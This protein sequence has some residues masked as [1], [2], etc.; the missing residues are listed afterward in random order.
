MFRHHILIT[1]RS[2]LC[3]KSTFLINLIGLSTGLAC[4]I[5]IYLWVNSEIEVDKFHLN[6]DRLYQVMFNLNVSG[7]IMTLENT[8]V[9]LAEAM[10]A[11]IPGVEA[12]VATNDFFNWQGKKGLIKVADRHT[13]VFGLHA[14][15]DFFDI[16]SFDLLAGDRK[17]LLVDNTSVVI[18]RSTA[19]K[20]FGHDQV[21]GETL[22]WKHVGYQGV[23]EITGIIEDVPANSTARFD[24][25]FPMSQLLQHD[26][27]AGGWT[28]SYAKTYFLLNEGSDLESV[29]KRLATMLSEKAEE[30]GDGSYFEAV[31]YSSKY[32]YG[33]FENGIQTGKGRITYIRLFS[34]IA[35]FILL[36]ACIN[37]MNLSTAKA[38][39]RL[40]ELGVKKTLGATRR[41]LIFQILT[42]SIILA[43]MACFLALLFVI[44][45][46]PQFNLL[47]GK[48]LVLS[49]EFDFIASL[50]LI[51]LVTGL[52]AGSY[53]AL[54][55]SGF[56]PIAVLRGR[57]DTW[58]G[59]I[60]I[61]KG[62]VVFQ[63]ALSVIFIMGLLVI[64]KQVKFALTKD[65]GYNRNNIIS[66]Q[67]KGE[68]YDRWSGLGEDGKSNE[69][70]Y[71]FMDGLQN[72]SGIVSS[73][74]IMHGNL[75][76]RVTGQGGISW[77][78]DPN[79]G[80]YSF[81]SPVVGYDFMKTMGMEV[82]H[83]RSFS[84]EQN[85]DYYTVMINETAA[86]LLGVENPLDMALQMNGV[87]N[88]IIGV[89]KDF[90][91]GSLYNTIE[92]LVFR[93]NKNGG[94][95]FSRIEHGAEKETIQ[96]LQNYFEEF[97]P[98]QTLEYSFLDDDYKQ[99][100]KSELLLS[101]LSRYFSGFAI[102]ISCLGL[103]GL[104][105]FTAERRRKEIGIR[106]VLGASTTGIVRL[107]SKE[108]YKLIL[109]A[110]IIAIPVGFLAVQRWLNEFDNHVELHWSIFLIAALI[111]VSIAWISIVVQTMQAALLDPVECIRD[112]R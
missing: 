95:I 82:L 63:F 74:S 57:F 110:L 21:I 44:T 77:Q 94:N 72:I 111:A 16:F 81:K 105:M 83:G 75:L 5:T 50:L 56:N 67:W 3:N 39:L 90:H 87:D 70:F 10:K 33:D 25:I 20:L 48:S 60:W 97:L 101:S 73:T 2:F 86:R 11:E 8:P 61:R 66:F 24:V 40:K 14:G 79:A 64:D 93:F 51:V 76:D 78:G 89:V 6:N 31:Q 37:F 52:L 29:N 58:L 68:L 15:Q 104:A 106:K 35:F 62:L 43:S 80:E 69:K 7:E 71:A 96:R 36:I 112:D 12:V 17:S 4:V 34:L 88:K 45:I 49:W 109:Y 27:W 28:G 19:L 54:Y 65:L 107:L 47:T 18:S 1:Y 32:L 26:R 108:Y 59:E 41:Q 46:I 55:L 22:S 9:P 102:L 91:Y 13:E 92:P 53:P 98:G 38:S 100:Y 84:R 103:F 42:E 23:Y 85:D 30:Y 99:Q